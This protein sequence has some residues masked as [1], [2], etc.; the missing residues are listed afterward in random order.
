MV[1]ES[2]TEPAVV[3]LIALPSRLSSTCST[4]RRSLAM[5]PISGATTALSVSPFASASGATLATTRSSV[6]R[7]SKRSERTS[8]WPAS[9]FE[10]SSTSLIKSSRCRALLRTI[11]NC[12][13]CSAFRGDSG[14]FSQG[15]SARGGDAP[16]LPQRH[17]H[18]HATHSSHQPPEHAQRAEDGQAPE[19]ERGPPCGALDRPQPR[20][21]RFQLAR[22]SAESPPPE[23]AT[24]RPSRPTPAVLPGSIHG[25]EH[26][27][28][29]PASPPWRRRSTR[30]LHGFKRGFR[31]RPRDPRSKQSGPRQSA[32]VSR[33]VW[34]AMISPSLRR[35][36][37]PVAISLMSPFSRPSSPRP[38]AT[39]SRN[40]SRE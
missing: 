23:S 6:A 30:S 9:I 17:A 29:P 37:R 34:S 26:E 13:A 31:H 25:S 24:R 15:R 4:R 12:F 3:N 18:H 5:T 11:P 27:R 8:I 32:S 28:P 20:P 7:R 33:Y 2:V 22:C 40:W 36:I 16:T 35:L 21:R 39:S 38:V 1:A 14:W 10:I 19:S